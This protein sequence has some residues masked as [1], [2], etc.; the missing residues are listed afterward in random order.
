MSN[1]KYRQRS[2]MNGNKAPF[3]NPQP[4]F[5]GGGGGNCQGYN[6][7]AV[8]FLG[9]AFAFMGVDLSSQAQ[10]GHQA[11]PAPLTQSNL[12][13]CMS[14]LLQYLLKSKITILIF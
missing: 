7:A 1:L 13:A 14:H 8:A 3:H 2:N 4:F 5:L 11:L 10:A 12:A 6:A 9:S